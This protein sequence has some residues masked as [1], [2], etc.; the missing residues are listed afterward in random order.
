MARKRI[1]SP[2]IW[3]SESFGAL[4]LLGKVLFIGMISQADDEGRGI[5]SSQLLKSKILPYDIVRIA[6]VDKALEDIGHK[7]STV[8]YECE[9][10]RYYCFENWKKW[11]YIQKPNPSKFPSPPSGEGESLPPTKELSDKSD[12]SMIPVSEEYRNEKKGIEKKGIERKRETR[13]CAPARELPT[14]ESETQA[15][16]DFILFQQKNPGIFIDTHFI[17]GIDFK[18]LSRKIEESEFLRQ[19]TLLSFYVKH[20]EKIKA[21]GYRD[22]KKPQDKVKEKTFSGQRDYSEE[23]LAAL[24]DN[25]DEIKL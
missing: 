10:K 17:E 16:E 25:I 4:D 21:D 13:A 7:T 8:F 18:L 22:F 3:E 11:Q 12:T 24:T 9:G 19:Q 6:D 15:K 20:Y 2:E 14:H 1:L 5:L 23:E